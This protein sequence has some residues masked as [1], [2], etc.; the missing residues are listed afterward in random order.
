MELPGSTYL[1]TLAAVSITFVGFTTVA[2]VFRQAQGADLSEYD[3]VLLRFFMVTGLIV[4]I[5]SLL[6]PL[7]GL[8]G[9]AA[10]LVWRVSSFALALVLL[11]RGIYFIRRQVRF[12]RRLLIYA[13]YVIA[14]V[15]F[16]GLFINA[17]GLF[18]EL[19]AGLY[20]LAATCLLVLAII[21]FIMALE[22]FLQPNKTSHKRSTPSK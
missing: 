12:E 15:A 3:I 20:A 17:L 16:L 5:F 4:T 22:R 14:V 9:I 6:P 21:A 1:L 10:S 11:W 13:L 19:S 2:V 8:F 7:L 18:I